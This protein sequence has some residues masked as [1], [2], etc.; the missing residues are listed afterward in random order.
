MS[1][2][3]DLFKSPAK[4]L[5]LF[6]WL[7]AIHIFGVGI[8]LIF[9]PPSWMSFFGFGEMVQNFFKVQGGVFHIVILYAYVSAARNLEKNENMVVLSITA[10][11]IATIF[12]GMYYLAVDPI[13]MVGLSGIVDFLM[14]LILLILFK[15]YLKAKSKNP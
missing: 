12:L 9:I 14:G 6:L 5:S 10:K 4:K 7:V 13:L 8:T 3:A 11:F 15:D 2:I 1:A